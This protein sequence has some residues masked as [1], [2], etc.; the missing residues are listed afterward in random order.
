MR[1]P[2][3]SLPLLTVF[4]TVLQAT[5]L[6]DTK[7]NYQ[8]Q[9]YTVN[10]N[11]SLI[12]LARQKAS[13]FRPTI[14]TS[15]PAW[16]DGPPATDIDA[17]VKY[18][19]N[20]Y[21]WPAIQSSINTNFS[22]FYTTVPAP[23]GAYNEP[24]DLH[25]IHQRSARP[26]AIPILFLHG[27]PSSA[28]EWASVIPSLVAPENGSDPAFH[29]VAPDIP[30]YGFSPAMNGSRVGVSRTQYA[31]VFASLMEQLGYDRY[32]VYS[33][34]VGTGITMALI[35]DYAERIIQHVTDFYAVFASNEDQARFASH[36]TSAEETEYIKS[37][38]AFLSTHSGYSS[39]QSTYPLSLAYAMNDSPAGF[40]AWVYQLSMTVNDRPYKK[41]EIIT[42]TL[43]LWI[44]GVYS[45]IRDYKEI[46]S[47]SML[48]PD[49]FFTVPTSV[50]QFGGVGG[51]T[52][53]ELGSFNYVVSVLPN[54]VMT[55]ADTEIASR[56]D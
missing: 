45:N 48:T 15:A 28:L 31:A 24:V 5:P 25:F 39:I 7:P 16:F 43:M 51:R 17:I 32:A 12:E 36:Q 35:V 41:E 4:T 53:P 18:W 27:W 37:L 6:K 14:D 19:V 3:L 49:K 2:A 13:T 9:P 21:D 33:T 8:P 10:V 22:H 34:D 38:T 47:T 11:P 46:F 40:M 55:K 54:T 29:V 56:L 20:E 42:N 52:Y 26:D 50:L 30:G 23:D 1:S 44:Q